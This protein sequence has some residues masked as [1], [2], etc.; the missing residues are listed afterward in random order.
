MCLRGRLVVLAYS[1][2]SRAISAAL[3]NSKIR[4]PPTLSSQANANSALLSSSTFSRSFRNGHI[5]HLQAP[6]C[7]IPRKLQHPECVEIVSAR[8]PIHAVGRNIESPE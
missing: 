3:Q 8:L 5:H 2:W 6:V 4:I 7:K 1:R